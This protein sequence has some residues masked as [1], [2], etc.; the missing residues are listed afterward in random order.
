MT[1][2]AV[3]ATVTNPPPTTVPATSA[4]ASE[5]VFLQL[6]VAQLKNQDPTAPADSLQFVTQLAQFSTL[7]QDTAMHAD[8]DTISADL[9]GAAAPAAAGTTPA[10]PA[11]TPTIPTLNTPTVPPLDPS[12]IFDPTP[13]TSSSS[14]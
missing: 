10:A 12:T 2:T 14:L 5:N 6:L 11:G 3:S 1:T 9:S 4:L 8:L 13:S 7:E